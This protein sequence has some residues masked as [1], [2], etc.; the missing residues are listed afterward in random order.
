MPWGID[1]KI[2]T[3][4]NINPKKARY[5]DGKANT[6]NTK[7]QLQKVYDFPWSSAVRPFPRLLI[8]S[9]E[10]AQEWLLSILS[11]RQGYSAIYTCS[12]HHSYCKSANTHEL[13]ETRCIWMECLVLL[14]N[15]CLWEKSHKVEGIFFICKIGIT[16]TLLWDTWKGP[17]L[18][19]KWKCCTKS[20]AEEECHLIK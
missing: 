19:K 11:M 7:C 16:L 3:K 18:R 9:G 8:C 1:I 10:R 4:Q 6:V 14:P 20:K 12:I 5:R 2:K 17:H 15:V 13:Y